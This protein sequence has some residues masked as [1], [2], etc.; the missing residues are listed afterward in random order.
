MPLKYCKEKVVE[1]NVD[2]YLLI[3]GQAYA[4]RKKEGTFAPPFMRDV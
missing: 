1:I 2:I 4:D 3:E